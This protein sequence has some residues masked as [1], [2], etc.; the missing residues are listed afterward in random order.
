MKEERV[1]L[2]RRGEEVA[3]NFLI[4]QGMVLVARNWRSGH[5]EVDLIVDDGEFLRFVE[6]KSLIYPNDYSPF[7]RVDK[8]KEKRLVAA[9]Q[10][11]VT[12]YGVKQEVVFDVVSVVFNGDNYSVEY[13]KEAFSPA[14]LY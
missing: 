3:L 9:A 13:F 2:G 14:L 5:K 8:G 12:R 7:E 11:F 1:L 4:E 6:V 10:N